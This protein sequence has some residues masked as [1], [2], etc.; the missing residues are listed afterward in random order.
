MIF[1][2]HLNQGG[3]QFFEPLN[4]E[5]HEKELKSEEENPFLKTHVQFLKKWIEENN[6]GNMNYL[7]ENM[8]ARWNSKKILQTVRSAICFLIPYYN[9]KYLPRNF[10]P[11]DSFFEFVS[12]YA[13]G[14]DY[15]RV[16]SNRLS[17]VIEEFILSQ[18]LD[19]KKN[20]DYR[21][22]TDSIPFFDRAHALQSG[23]GFIGKNTM[24]IRPGLGSYFFISTVLTSMSYRELLSTL[25]R[26]ETPIERLTRLRSLN[27]GSCDLCQRACPTGALDKDYQINASSCLS[28]LTIENREEIPVEFQEHLKNT[29]YGCDICQD[30]CPY[31]FKTKAGSVFPDLAENFK[32][33][34]PN[35]FEVSKMNQMQYEAWFGG[36][37]LTRA[38]RL[39]LIRNALYFLKATS[40]VKLKESI[41]YWKSQTT[42]DTIKSKVLQIFD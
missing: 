9:K 23:L 27:C 11:E 39:G 33:Y 16:I 12:K 22:V 6:H 17:L 32:T 18:E 38:K 3:F 5:F 26:N 40:P 37:A 35:V 21:I 24:L 10:R 2:E 15:H 14:K 1:S 28:Y 42:D 30:V 8:E 31:N 25:G 29:V 19:S 4:L 36:T 13:Q 7:K 41:E 34:S 20:F